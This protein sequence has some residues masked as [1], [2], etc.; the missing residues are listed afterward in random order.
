MTMSAFVMKKMAAPLDKPRPP[1]VPGA[2]AASAALAAASMIFSLLMGNSA[3]YSL[4]Y[5]SLASVIIMLV[6]LYL[7]GNILIMGNVV[8]FVLFTHRKEARR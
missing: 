6:W 2:L 5:G 4:V 8:I 1:V 7:C 3:R